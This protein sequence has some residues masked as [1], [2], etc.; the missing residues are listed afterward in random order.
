ML[1][2]TSVLWRKN[3]QNDPHTSWHK[4]LHTPHC[5]PVYQPPSSNGTSRWL[6]IDSLLYWRI[7]RYWQDGRLVQEGHRVQVEPFGRQTQTHSSIPSY[8]LLDPNLCPSPL[9]STWGIYV[10]IF[11]A[12]LT[13]LAENHLDKI[14]YIHMH[15]KN[16]AADLNF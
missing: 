14:L 6:F 1:T 13:N 8:L 4:Y 12:S 9:T 5:D 3:H 2:S 16:Y 10:W 7:I 15:T 11:T